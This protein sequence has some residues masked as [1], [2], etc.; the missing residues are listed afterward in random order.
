MDK[1]F[2]K[3][4]SAFFLASA[5]CL[6]SPGI[7]AHAAENVQ[8][9]VKLSITTDRS[10]YEL[11][12]NIIAKISLENNS[13]NDITDISIESTVPEGYH[14]EE[15]KSSV[16]RS[17][18]IM[19]GNSISS[20]LVF[21]PDKAENEPT[22]KE[23]VTTA[24]ADKDDVHETTVTAAVSQTSITSVTSTS[25][26]D[27]ESNK[28]GSNMPLILA[29]I[30]G[31]VIPAA[32][33]AV[34]IFKKKGV[35]TGIMILLCV[36]SAGTLY[37]L[38][39]KADEE[40]LSMSV[41]EEVTVDDKTYELTLSA[42]YTM[43]TEDMQAVVEEYYSNNSEEIVAVE[44]VQEAEN[45]FSEKEV[46]EFLAERGF[47]EYPVT[48]DFNMDGTYTDEA[49]ASSDSDEKHPMYQ[50]YFVGEDGSV[51]SIFIVG[52]TI[53]ANPASYNLE[54]DNDAQVLVSETETLTSYTEMG[55][56]L[57]TTIP[58]DSA[59]ILKIVDQITSQKLNEVTF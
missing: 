3:I 41:T 28:K 7:R 44:E 22:E 57:Y 10:D 56:K 12:D 43:Q 36:T 50:T 55:N 13:G 27:S 4:A 24:A 16:L 53:T 38:Q 47:T 23:T 54:S 8:D 32:V 9:G 19:S 1:L 40:D 45:V 20:E 42:K 6:C 46:I 15:G 59:I 51:W 5:L 26:S 18:Y 35:K 58:K 30:G 2:S 52:R 39:A 34:I 17:T 37:P 14:L 49:E 48:Y 29:I 25:V 11:G 31:I 21:I 33:A